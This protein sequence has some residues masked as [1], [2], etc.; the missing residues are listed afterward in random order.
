T[1]PQAHPVR[2]GPARRR[3]EAQAGPR[4]LRERRQEMT[5]TTTPETPTTPD[6]RL[7]S[8]LAPA[9]RQLE[10]SV[11]VWLRLPQVYPRP[12]DA[13]AALEGMAD[14]L[15][16]QAEA[17][18]AE[19]PLLVVMLMGGTG[20]GKSSLL[21]A[22]AGGNIAQASF[23]RP[24]TRDPVVYYHESLRT[25]RLD[26][27]LRQCRLVPHDRPEL[28]QKILAGTPDLDRTALVN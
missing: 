11:R 15:R 21:N 9:L 25:D 17:L 10:H 24:T 26:P 14:D 12:L 28:E 18:E 19:K 5:P 7:L 3:P 4:D 6:G 20:V 1:G 13:V 23:A 2:A 16:R 27:T 22:L 8:T